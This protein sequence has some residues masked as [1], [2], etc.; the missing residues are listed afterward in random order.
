MTAKETRYSISALARKTGLSVHTLRYYEKAGIIRHVERTPSGRRVYGEDSVA[1]LIGALCLKQ[2]RVTLAQI[3]EFFDATVKGEATLTHRLEIMNEARNNL[4]NMQESVN[5]SLKL[6]NFFIEGTQA[7]VEALKNGEDPDEAFPLIT[8]A[9]IAQL[10]T[11]MDDGKLAPDM[12][13]LIAS[14]DK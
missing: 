5:R 8:R 12:P 2:A 7:A 11:I 14:L 4:L 13:S 6:V 1:C 9:G 3:K 10:P